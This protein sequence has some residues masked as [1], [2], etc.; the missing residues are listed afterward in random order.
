M[1]KTSN[2]IGAN[3]HKKTTTHIQKKPTT[4]TTNKQKQ[5]RIFR[6]QTVHFSY[7]KAPTHDQFYCQ[8]FHIVQS[9]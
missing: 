3:T 9:Y 8:L 5:Q 7:V 2:N 6:L 4:T 1:N